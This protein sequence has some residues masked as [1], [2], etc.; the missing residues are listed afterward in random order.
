MTQYEVEPTKWAADVLPTA[1]TFRV[2]LFVYRYRC[3]QT[4]PLIRSHLF[5]RLPIV[6]RSARMT[7][8]LLPEIR[9]R[10]RQRSFH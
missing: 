6:I 10:I 2:D 5:L 3:R 1:E 8:S 4:T 7:G 9:I